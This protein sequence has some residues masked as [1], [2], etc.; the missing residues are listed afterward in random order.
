MTVQP[1][2]R[3]VASAQARPLDSVEF[4]SGQPVFEPA[5]HLGRAQQVFEGLV[6]TH[7]SE[8]DEFQQGVL[9]IRQIVG[10][11]LYGGRWPEPQELPQLGP[12][13]RPGPPAENGGLTRSEQLVSEDLINLYRKTAPAVT[14]PQ[15]HKRLA[16]AIHLCQ[17]GLQGRVLRRDY[18]DYWMSSP[19]TLAQDAAQEQQ[20]WG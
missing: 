14:S 17:S 1:R 12:S 9:E 10:E 19:G 15:Q 4:G 5:A 20:R 11:V 13:K 2:R 8:R 7:P 6:A 3:P 16:S 18:P